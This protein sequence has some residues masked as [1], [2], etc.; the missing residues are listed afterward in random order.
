MTNHEQQDA[1]LGQEPSYEAQE[2]REAERRMHPRIYVASL[3]DYNAGTLHGAWL[4]ADQAVDAIEDGIAA[5]LAASP[6]PQA[7]EWAIHDYNDFGGVDLGEHESLALV[8]KVAAGLAAY[9]EAFASW[10]RLVGRD[11]GELERFE[12]AYLGNWESLSTYAE[13]LLDNLGVTA[14][15]TRL[16]EQNLGEHLALYVHWDYEALGRDLDY[17]GDIRTQER[18]DGSLD[19]FEGGAS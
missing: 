15:L 18:D 2:Q 7:E 14:E 3:S 11:P 6:T 4:D 1:G 9:G 13:G 8:A 16:V 5:M 12:D 17:G 10:A 19:V